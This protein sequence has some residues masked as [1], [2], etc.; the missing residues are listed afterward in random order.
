M[1]SIYTTFIIVNVVKTLVLLAHIKLF[2]WIIPNN[3]WSGKLS[4]IIKNFKPKLKSKDSPYVDFILHPLSGMLYYL[5]YR[6]LSP[7]LRFPI[8]ELMVVLESVTWEFLYE[9]WW[10]R[11]SITDLIV[12]P[13]AGIILGKT[14]IY[15]SKKF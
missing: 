14:F 6:Y 15:L 5:S 1:I 7:N 2:S 13:I 3:K 8:P 9:V 10:W 12:T 4:K 11:P